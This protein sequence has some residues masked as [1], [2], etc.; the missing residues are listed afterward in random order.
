MASETSINHPEG[1]LGGHFVSIHR[2]ACVISKC[3]FCDISHSV[4]TFLVIV[5]VGTK[6][7]MLF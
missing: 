1:R 7:F 4:K 2:Q 5:F 3:I 6:L